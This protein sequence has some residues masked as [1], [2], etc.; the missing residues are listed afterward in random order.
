MPR[1]RAPRQAADFRSTSELAS[2]HAPSGAAPP[3][4]GFALLVQ[5]PE[6]RR[7]WAIHDV[8][9]D[10][11]HGGGAVLHRFFQ[12]QTV[13]GRIAFG[14]GE[15]GGFRHEERD[16]QRVRFARRDAVLVWQEIH[17]IRS[18]GWGGAQAIFT[19]K[20]AWKLARAKLPD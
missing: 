15:D 20:T 8:G 14:F 5:S 6:P 7:D 4:S 3:D 18:H 17:G 12:G 13:A 10:G 11:G 16:D 1:L 19:K 9:Q 2:K